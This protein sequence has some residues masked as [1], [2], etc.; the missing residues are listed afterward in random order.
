MISSAVDS[1]I[2]IAPFSPITNRPIRMGVLI[3]GGGQKHCLNFLDQIRSGQLNA[4]VPLV[5]AS[6]KSCKG[7]ERARNA[8]LDCIVLR[9]RDYANVRLSSASVF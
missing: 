5:I 4:E 2:S 9:S 6:Q 7:I 8:G 1:E 3:S